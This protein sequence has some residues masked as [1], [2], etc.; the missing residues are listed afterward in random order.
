MSV[1]RHRKLCLALLAALACRR[2][3]ERAPTPPPAPADPTRAL[4]AAVVDP[5]RWPRAAGATDRERALEDIGPYEPA[6]RTVPGAPL[7]NT[8]AHYWTAL[9]GIAWTR[10]VDIDLDGEP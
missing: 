7:V 4:L 6:D 3:D 2:A 10:D 9:V 8:N 5:W 1:R